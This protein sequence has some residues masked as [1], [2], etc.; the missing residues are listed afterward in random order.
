MECCNVSL[1]GHS[2][3]DDACQGHRN[4]QITATAKNRLLRSTSAC[5]AR[6]LC[7]SNSGVNYVGFTSVPTSPVY[8]EPW[9]S[10][11]NLADHAL[12]V[13]SRTELL[14]Y[15]R[16]VETR[17]CQGCYLTTYEGV[18]FDA[19]LL[20][21]MC[22][23]RIQEN[24]REDPRRT[25]HWESF[26]R[27]RLYPLLCAYLPWFGVSLATVPDLEQAVVGFTAPCAWFDQD[28]GKIDL[29]QI[30]DL[31]TELEQD[32]CS[33]TTETLRDMLM[34][35]GRFHYTAGRNRP[36]PKGDSN[37]HVFQLPIGVDPE[38][39]RLWSVTWETF[40]F[41]LDP[42]DDDVTYSA[43]DSDVVS[44]RCHDTFI[45]SLRH[46][47]DGWQKFDTEMEGE[48]AW[49]LLEYDVI[50]RDVVTPEQADR[51]ASRERLCRSRY[52][53]HKM[54]RRR[55]AIGHY[56]YQR[57]EHLEASVL[58]TNMLWCSAMERDWLQF[59]TLCSEDGKNCNTAF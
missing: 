26:Q 54:R 4:G 9:P 2:Y 40:D 15:N 8:E 50:K 1:P 13:W 32:L 27:R 43:D 3:I 7:L 57:Y 21:T 6:A 22:L 35:L 37:K 36:A 51:I 14:H 39:L 30:A 49:S 20:H 11:G 56:F 42:P 52:C 28:L 33:N 59:Q 38:S 47:Y 58:Q 44:Q 24:A 25:A 46:W 18:V 53:E 34:L 29:R 23:S 16:G 48:A 19:G 12:T 55:E 5:E 45:S 31:R 17:T 10:N 41:S